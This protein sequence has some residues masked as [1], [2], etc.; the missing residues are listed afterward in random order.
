MYFIGD[1]FKHFSGLWEQKLS[2]IIRFCDS[3]MMVG[4][5]GA[6]GFL[7]FLVGLSVFGSVHSASIYQFGPYKIIYQSLKLMDSSSPPM[8]NVT[9]RF[10]QIE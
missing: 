1:M 10:D 6:V 4:G 8:L 3:R 9:I 5:S 7:A 2:T